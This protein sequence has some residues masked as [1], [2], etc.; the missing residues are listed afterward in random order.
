V[1]FAAAKLLPEER[2]RPALKGKEEEEVHAV[3]LNDDQG[4]P[5]NN[6]VS[7]LN[8]NTQQEDADAEF[9]ENACRNLC[10]F[11]RPPP[12]IQIVSALDML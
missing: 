10:R 11:A 9:E 1:T 12:L 4:D 7:S 5:E 8:D 3:Y 6:A 2:D